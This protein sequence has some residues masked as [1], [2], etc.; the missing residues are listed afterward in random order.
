M[1]N[2]LITNK[3]LIHFDLS[4]NNFSKE[5]SEIIGEG[6]EQNKT[7]YGFHFRGNYGYIDSKGF[8]VLKEKDFTSLHSLV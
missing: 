4:S 1:S 8:L 3:S 2:L 6:L 7:I 5:E